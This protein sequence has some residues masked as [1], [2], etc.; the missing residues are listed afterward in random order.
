MAFLASEFARCLKSQ[1]KVETEEDGIGDGIGAGAGAG[2]VA[3]AKVNIVL[4][5]QNI[6]IE[7]QCLVLK[8]LAVCQK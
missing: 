4:S 1:K 2:E 3:M 6:D 5:R 8:I 7:S